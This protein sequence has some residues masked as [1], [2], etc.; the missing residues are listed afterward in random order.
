MSAAPVERW[1]AR[2]VVLRPGEGRALA[3]SFAYFF[4][5]L[6]GY[7]VL[8]PLRDE[9][10]IA[11]GVKNLPW[12]FTATFL[13]LLAVAPVFAALVARLPRAR[14]IPLVYHFFVANIAIF[15][16]LLVFDVDKP[17]VARVFFVWISV[18]NLF[19]VSVFWS[20]MADLFASEQGKR[21][22]G[23]IAAGGSAGALAGPAI[24]FGLAVPLGP[25]NLLIVAAV[26]LELA[27]L[28]ARRLEAAAPK[29][30]VSPP[31]T[32]SAPITN[33][34]PAAPLGGGWW[35]GIV[36]VLRSP[37]LGGIA[38]W[39]FLLSLAGTFL[40]FQQ[41]NIVAA[42]SD[43]PAVRTRIFASI[44][45][46]IGILTIIVQFFATGRLITR[47]GVG[48]AAAFL[49]LVFA[50]G[51][52][53]LAFSPMLAVVI[54][55]QAIQRTANF[56][57][58]NPAREVLFTVVDRTE[59]YKAKN[60][61]DIVVFRG[62]DAANGWLFATLRGAGFELTTISLATVPVAIA[63][64]V[65][66]LALGRAQEERARRIALEQTPAGT[67]G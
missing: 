50:L 18:F 38:T 37:Y 3:W 12:L 41:A 23:F 30:K 49:P 29:L 2:V 28:C 5:L 10:G 32:A 7:Y 11:G 20:F 21:L 47:F 9:M 13:V 22:F 65:L 66:A 61:I 64:F 51:F 46:A 60:I 4:C 1:L 6:A 15:W 42:A 26:L 57:L 55:F 35:D 63:W 33:E 39:V 43:D 19:A 25:V 53:V 67:S 36:M 52:L 45:L 58:S 8:R 27:V 40:Y 14:F 44:D 62:A 54:A 48:P 34:R 59:K 56:A 24:T 17:L 16:L 31:E